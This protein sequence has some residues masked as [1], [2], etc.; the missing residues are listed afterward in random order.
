MQNDTWLL[1]E[2]ANKVTI[3]NLI[4]ENCFSYKIDLCLSQF[5]LEN[6]S[7]TLKIFEGVCPT[8]LLDF[9]ELGTLGVWQN[10]K[11]TTLREPKE[12]KNYVSRKGVDLLHGSMIPSHGH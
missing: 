8:N 7:G 3:N 10:D 1:W 2:T 12:L 5:D 4:R 6:L 11:V 9:S